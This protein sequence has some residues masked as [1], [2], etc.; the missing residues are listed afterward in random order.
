MAQGYK[1]SASTENLTIV[2]NRPARPSCIIWDSAQINKNM[3]IILF[4]KLKYF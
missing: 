1:Y 2:N 4:E 3:Y